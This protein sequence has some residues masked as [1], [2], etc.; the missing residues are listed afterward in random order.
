MP[1]LVVAVW[2]VLASA[3]MF[4]AV[5]LVWRDWTRAQR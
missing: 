4:G 1:A 5:A 2:G 3:G